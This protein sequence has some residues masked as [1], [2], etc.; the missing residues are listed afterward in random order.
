MI[1]NYDYKAL[2]I[3][4]EKQKE[5]NCEMN[6]LNFYNKAGYSPLCLALK[7]DLLQL[8]GHAQDHHDPMDDVI[9]AIDEKT[10]KTDVESDAAQKTE[11]DGDGMDQKHDDAEEEQKQED[12]VMDDDD[13]DQWQTRLIRICIAQKYEYNTAFNIMRC[14]L[15]CVLMSMLATIQKNR[16]LIHCVYECIYECKA[17]QN[18]KTMANVNTFISKCTNWKITQFTQSFK[19]SN[20]LKTLLSSIQDLLN[21]NHAEIAEFGPY[22]AMAHHL[23]VLTN[24]YDPDRVQDILDEIEKGE[25][26]VMDDKVKEYMKNYP[27]VN[28]MQEEDDEKTTIKA[29]S[30]WMYKM[31]LDNGA[32]VNFPCLDSDNTNHMMVSSLGFCLTNHFDSMEH[33]KVIQYLLDRHAKLTHSETSSLSEL[34]VKVSTKKE[35]EIDIYFGALETIAKNS[36]VLLQNVTDLDGNN[37]I[38]TAILH[39]HAFNQNK[40]AK[41]TMNDTRQTR[42]LSQLCNRYPFW[43][44]Q[45]NIEGDY[46]LY[47]SVKYRDVA[48]IFA[49]VS[50]LSA[51]DYD[52]L[53]RMIQQRAF[54]S[55]M[56]SWMVDL[57]FLADDS[58]SDVE[59]T[60]IFMELFGFEAIF[61]WPNNPDLNSRQEPITLMDFIE[62]KDETQ[63]NFMLN[64]L[65]NRCNVLE[66]VQNKNILENDAAPKTQDHQVDAPNE[67]RFTDDQDSA[68]GLAYQISIVQPTQE[69][70]PNESEPKIDLPHE[71]DIGVM[72]DTEEKD[73]SE[74]T[75]PQD[76]DVKVQEPEEEDEEED[77]NQLIEDDT[78]AVNWIELFYSMLVESFSTADLYTDIIIMVELYK[79]RQQWWVT[80]MVAFLTAPYLVSYSALGSIIQH[81]IHSFFL[82]NDTLNCCQWISFNVIVLILMTPLCL[83]YFVVIDVIFMIYVLFSTFLFFCSCSK[84]DIRDFIDD[85]LFKKLFGMN[86]T[87]I[88]G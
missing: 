34:F 28:E 49:L 51:N 20:D 16:K 9:E 8:D 53:N 82:F 57:I 2:R 45:C 65:K 56:I 72:Q 66:Y 76:E 41:N 73:E 31:L 6:N 75:D 44:K 17:A 77:T 38:H 54:A 87:Q 50:F 84:L 23:K 10:G 86:R 52:A 48:S 74:E 15:N 42:I 59:I 13:D 55:S 63:R 39:H 30:H 18:N 62:N 4:F 36:G 70:V 7:Y 58:N 60:K 68:P 67:F 40:D 80:F 78:E 83:M 21:A 64:V 69:Q 11:G 19:A 29:G 33:V 5:K 88:I 81:R 61:C 1:R 46:P 22:G 3:L 71:D 26:G 14:K 32:D 25:L 43:A 47:L 85:M 37:P 35:H 12:F 24:H 79:A 27:F